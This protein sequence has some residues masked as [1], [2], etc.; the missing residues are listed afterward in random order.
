MAY[1]GF[2]GIMLIVLVLMSWRI[3]WNLSRLQRKTSDASLDLLRIRDEVSDNIP[4]SIRSLD[5]SLR[6]MRQNM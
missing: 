3:L 1:E 5:D 6:S 2:V 4:K